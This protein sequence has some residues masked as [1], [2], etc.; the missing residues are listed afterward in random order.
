MVH[1]DEK[2]QLWAVDF[3]GELWTFAFSE[4]AANKIL[5]KLQK[6]S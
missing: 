5:A 4:K 1:W 3:N 6:S 2:Q